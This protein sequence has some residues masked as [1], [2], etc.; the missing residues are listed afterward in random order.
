MDKYDE[1]E[2]EPEP[3]FFDAQS[4]TPKDTTDALVKPVK[5]M[6]KKSLESEPLV[7]CSRLRPKPC[8]HALRPNGRTV[9]NVRRMYVNPLVA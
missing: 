6:Q 1:D 8:D 2:P 9:Q 3:I 4:A 5:P 7:P